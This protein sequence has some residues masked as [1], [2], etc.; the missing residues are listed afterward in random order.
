MHSQQEEE[1]EAEE[2]QDKMGSFSGLSTQRA[3]NPKGISS[4][5]SIIL[6]L[7]C[8]KSKPWATGSKYYTLPK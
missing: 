7:F 5:I 8:K 2:E 3:D 1:E 6:G 4:S